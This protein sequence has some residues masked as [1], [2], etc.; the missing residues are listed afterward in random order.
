MNKQINIFYY[1]RVSK[2]CLDLI[3]MMDNYGILNKFLLQCIDD[4]NDIPKGLDRVPTLIVVGIPKP[5]VANE[6]VKWFNDNKPYLQQQGS[7]LQNKK[8]LYNITKTMY[9]QQGPKGFSSN[10]LEGLSDNFAYSDENFNYAQPKTFCLYGNDGD[11]IMTPPKDGKL[12]SETQKNLICEIEK[13]QKKQD[14]E[15]KV[16][17][18][19]EQ[20]NKI[21]QKERDELMKNH[22]GI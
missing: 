18:K 3:R 11:V 13:N 21:M 5:L 8:L 17:M 12:N 14:D 7:D 9:D 20:L 10:E 22:L 19:Q 16:Y 6:A 4:M 15:C 2:L 1:S